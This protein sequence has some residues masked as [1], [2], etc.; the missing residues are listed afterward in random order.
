M[1]EQILL[2]RVKIRLPDETVSDAFFLEMII[3]VKDRLNLRLGTSI[4]PNQFYSILVDAVIK[5]Y[6]RKYY[7]GIKSESIDSISTNFTD[8]ILKEYDLE[9]KTYL[10]NEEVKKLNV[11][12]F[13]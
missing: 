5:M 2:E 1:E 12:R 11:V 3:T 8:D 13:L 6:R 4:L 7:E 10:D 9:I